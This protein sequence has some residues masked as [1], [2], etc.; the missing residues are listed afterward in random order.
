MLHSLII[1]AGL[2][3]T[4]K[5]TLAEKLRKITRYDLY[6]LLATRREFGQKRYNPK[7]TSEVLIAMYERTEDSLQDCKGVILDLTYTT[8]EGRRFPYVIAENHQV[9]ATIIE[10]HCSEKLSKKR[11]R[12]RPK[13]DGLVVEP[14]NPKAYDKLAQRWEEINADIEVF[15]SVSLT[16]LKYNSETNQ[17]ERVHMHQGV[18]ELTER[19][20]QGINTGP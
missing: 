5:S 11:M 18:K 12:K 16:Y 2:P 13:N 10:C 4:G 6:S 9:P 15:Q 14:R 3:G 20:I 17:V 19:I 1:M 8:R 7:R